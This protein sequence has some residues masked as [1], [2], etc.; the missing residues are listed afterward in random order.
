M[1]FIAAQGKQP[2][3]YPSAIEWAEMRLKRIDVEIRQLEED[4][5][6][7]RQRLHTLR[8]NETLNELSTKNS[9]IAS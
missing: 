8:L 3:P 6:R 5:E 9:Q 2:T 7:V 4:K 1:Q